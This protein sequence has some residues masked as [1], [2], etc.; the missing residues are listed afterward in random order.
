[1]ASIRLQPP[2]S[3]N[4]A[5]PDEWPRWKRRFEQFQNASGLAGEDEL[6]QVSTLLYCLGEAAD[7]VLTST[8]I[9]DEDRQQYTPVMT[10]FDEFFKVRRNVIFERARFNRRNQLEG[11]SAEEYITALYSLVETCDY[12]ELREELLRDRLVVGIRDAAL[13]ERLQMDVDL[14]LEKAKKIVRQKEAVRE[15][16]SQLQ[17]K[18]T[19]KDPIVL[20]EVRHKPQTRK[21]GAS[22]KRANKTPQEAGSHSAKPQCGRCGK[23]KHPYDKCPAKGAICRRCNRKGHFE[24]QCFSKT[25]AAST[26]ELSVESAFLDTVAT[27]QECSWSVT[28]LLKNR[29]VPFKLDTSTEV[30]AISE[31]VYKTLVGVALQKSSRPLYGPAH[32][33]LEVLGEFTAK[34]EHQQLVTTQTI[35]V[36]RGLKTNLQGLPAIS[37]LQL[38]CRV[39]A[40]VSGGPDIRAQF[41]DVFRGLGNLGDAYTIQLKADAV[42]HSLNIP[43]NV[44]IPLRHKVQAELNRMESLGVI[45]KASGPTPWCAGMVVVPKRSGAVRIC[46]DLKPLKTL[47]QLAGGKVFSKLYANSGFWQ[48]PL[49]ED[50]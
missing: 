24:A 6:R 40:T 25:A 13:S 29:E 47:A 21:G 14:T 12:G 15:Q 17:G 48:I 44:P 38:L 26:D 30:T 9:S 33:T 39:H 4:F 34:L 50:S 11:E 20:E 42:P 35:F 10:K 23:D 32:Q 37:S 27:K 18:G 16:H 36:I 43:R 19:K 5:K 28:L 3:F 45:T 1:M 8:N 46:V 2:E 7:D 41:P 31:D 22:C 49:A